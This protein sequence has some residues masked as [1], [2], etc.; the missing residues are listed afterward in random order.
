[1]DY[2]Y[3]TPLALFLAW[4][5]AQG[6]T[7]L[8]ALT[9]NR[10]RRKLPPG[11][12]PLPI[13][14][15]LHLLGNQPH[16]SLAKLADFH[17]P[18]MRLKLGQTT[19][20]VISSSDMAKQVL[21]KQGSAFSNR[22]VPN[23]VHVDNYHV[24]SVV[25]LP[26]SRPQWKNLRKILNNYIFSVSKLD[27]S[28]H[29]RYK[30]IEE[31]VVYCQR[32]SQMGEAVDIG[33]TIFRTLLNLLSNILFSKDL[34]DPYENSGKE[35][36]ELVEGLLLGLG[37]IDLADY[38]PVLKIVDPQGKR[39]YNSCLRK[40]L[41]LFRELVNERLELRKSQNDQKTDI[42]EALITASEQSPQE[43]DVKNIPSICLDV[44]VAGTDTSSN[45]ME[46]AM[47]EIL[48]APE[49][50]KKAQAELAEVIGEGKAIEEADIL[51]LP[52]LQCI[53]K[54]TYRLH[55]PAPFLVPR[56]AG[57]DVEVCGYT[58][59]KG[60]KLMVNVWAIGRDATLWEDPLVFNPDRF[61][62]SKMDVRGQDFE[63]IPFGAGRRICPGLPLAVR[64]VPV[65]LGTLL[66]TFK[67]KIEGDVAPKDL[68]MQD[69][70]GLTLARLRPLRAV[71][72]PL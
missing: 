4:T 41:K 25:W 48:K 34:A 49:V 38:F 50:M 8:L 1:M 39:R 6:F 9:T 62:D 58:V 68:D 65:M 28:Q 3:A 16:R 5:L 11:P 61:M 63:L 47:A 33:G 21:Q 54:E 40:L 30:K 70:F 37:K 2:Y 51:R 20:V 53:I 23:S 24:S 44:F 72:L 22:P 18:I 10:S 57:E 15:N 52:Y 32:S 12:S 45:V 14:G 66:N 26:A 56:E 43:I 17:G 27:A 29:F 7:L 69:K 13:I 59:P 55:P 64:M 60:S 36:K 46:W 42:I 19:A 71:P 31:L 67:W 35:F